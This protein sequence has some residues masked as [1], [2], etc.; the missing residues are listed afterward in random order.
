MIQLYRKGNNLA[1]AREGLAGER[2]GHARCLFQVCTLR[3]LLSLRVLRM[4]HYEASFSFVGLFSFIRGGIKKRRHSRLIV[5][6][7]LQ[8]FYGRYL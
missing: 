1:G 2:S 5:R 7:I 3:I 6:E 8:R 4:E